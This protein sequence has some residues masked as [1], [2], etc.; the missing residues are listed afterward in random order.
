MSK[1]EC[2]VCD[3]DDPCEII[4]ENNL[5]SPPNQCPWRRTGFDPEWTYVPTP[6]TIE[7][8]ITQRCGTCKHMYLELGELR[9][10][11]QSLRCLDS[12]CWC[13]EWEVMT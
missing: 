2:R 13:P 9:C 11:P 5:C 12:Q 4:G 6:K 3:P 7:Y 1:F 10:T 8:P